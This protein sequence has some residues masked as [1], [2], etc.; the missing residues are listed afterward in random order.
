MTPNNFVGSIERLPHATFH[1]QRANI[2]T[3]TGTPV[4]RPTRLNPLRETYDSISYYELNWT[5]M[6]DEK[7]K[8]YL[9]I[10]NWMHNIGFPQDHAQY[11]D[12]DKDFNLK[13]NIS[14]IILNSNKNPT[15]TV[16]FYDAFPSFL[17]DLN[18]DTT[19]SET[20]PLTVDVTFNYNY[21]EIES[22]I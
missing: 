20:K 22:H 11:K 9:E 17:G 16:T 13:S 7:M 14:V 6:V 12:S 5:F 21:Y 19:L 10:F 3:I 2:P 4:Q 15:A 8:N 18:F 1:L